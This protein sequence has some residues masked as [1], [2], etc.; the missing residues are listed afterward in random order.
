MRKWLINFLKD[1]EQ[2]YTVILLWCGGLGV[3]AFSV[4]VG[5]VLVMR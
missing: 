1:E 4:A 2:A 5:A 3:L